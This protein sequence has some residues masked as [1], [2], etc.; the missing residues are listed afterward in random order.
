MLRSAY[1]FNF[2]KG[3]WGAAR[4]AAR[5]KGFADEYIKQ[6]PGHGDAYLTL[7][8]YNYYVDIAP[9]FIKVIR[10]LLLLPSGNKAEGLRQLERAARDGNLF[11]PLADARSLTFTDRSK[12]ACR[13]HRDRRR[14]V[15]RF[16]GNAVIRLGLADLYAHPTVEAFAARAAVHLP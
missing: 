8:L 15:R 11:A 12:A 16:P 14:Y 9:V 6:H 5:A 7:G 4:D 3:L 1:R 13:V 2:D 10:V